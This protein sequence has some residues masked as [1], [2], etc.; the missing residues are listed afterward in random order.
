MKSAHDFVPPVL[1]L[2]LLVA[3]FAPG[4]TRPSASVEGTQDGWALA[5]PAEEHLD[6]EMISAMLGRVRSGT[7]RNVHSVIIA[8][9]GK[10]AVEEYFP[11]T[12]G[13]RR[14]QVIRR[15]SPVESTSATKSVTSIL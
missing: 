12:E 1:P 11:R 13:D 2:T 7:Y 3:S 10:L 4:Q 8:R 6:A 9:H 15:A 14:E 5:S